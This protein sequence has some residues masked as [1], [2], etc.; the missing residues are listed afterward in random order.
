MVT[1]V[2]STDLEA[3]YNYTLKW[4]VTDDDSGVDASSIYL[5]INDLAINEVDRITK[6]EIE[7]GYECTYTAVITT[8]G[9][10]NVVYFATDNSGNE[11]TKNIT[12]KINETTMVG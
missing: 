10:F 4:K 9:T 12:F 5:T 8:T 7:N 2:P 1:T 3:G 11:A 6:T